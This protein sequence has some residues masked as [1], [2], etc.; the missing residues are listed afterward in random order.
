MQNTNKIKNNLYGTLYV[1]AT[2]I[3]NI[4]DIT[5][6]AVDILSKVDIIATE[7]TRSSKKILNFYGI[8]TKQISYHKHNELERTNYLIDILKNGKSVAL[9]SD[10]GTPG[11]SDPG[12]VII[13]SAY[14]ENIK[15]SPI[16]G[17]SSVI[18]ALSV[19]GKAS[20]NFKFIGFLPKKI[21]QKI[22]IL[23][24]NSNSDFSLIFFESPNRVLKTLDNLKIIYEGTKIIIIAR[25]ITKMYEDININSIDNL[26]TYYQENN[27]EKLRG[28]FVF[29]IPKAEA[30]KNF[31]K[32]YEIKD[33][34]NMLL[35]NNISYNVAIK[36]TCNHFEL[37]K[38]QIYDKYIS[39]AKY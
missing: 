39:L 12:D 34:I 7:D 37:K 19:S 9:V 3:G 13:S 22:D 33:F 14:K 27:N 31:T 30:V 17:V 35:K 23:K 25:E 32:D 18:S 24:K 11:I 28:E 2:P 38:N 29:I 26:I 6:R 4:N 8:N 16:P 5:F 36:I 20:N 10:A 21:M 15:V 1:V